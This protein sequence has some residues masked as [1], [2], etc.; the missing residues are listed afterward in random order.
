MRSHRCLPS[1]LLLL[2]A[3]LGPAPAQDQAVPDRV[4]APADFTAARAGSQVAGFQSVRTAYD[5]G[6]PG[7]FARFADDGVV[8]ALGDRTEVAFRLLGWE[9]GGVRR[10]IESRVEPPGLENGRVA[11]RRGAVRERYEPNGDGVEQTFVFDERPEGAGDLL[12][13][14]GV[15]GNVVA[16]AVPAAHQALRFVAA[17]GQQLGYGEAWAI[18]HAGRRVPMTTSYDGL[19][20]IHL[21]VPAEFVESARFPLVVDPVIGTA[22]ALAG[23]TPI[24]PDVT[25]DET[26]N[27][28]FVVWIDYHTLYGQIFDGDGVPLGSPFTLTTSR[29][30]TAIAV[31]VVDG[32]PAGDL[33]VAIYSYRW[34][35]FGETPRLGTA[36]V[37]PE[38]RAVRLLDVGFVSS[39]SFLSPTVTGS[40]DGLVGIGWL[41]RTTSATVVG[42][43]TMSLAHYPAVS[44]GAHIL[45]DSF[46]T[47]PGPALG[48]R[49]AFAERAYR[50]TV[51]GVQTS[52]ARLVWSRWFANPAPGDHDIY[53]AEI[54]LRR[55]PSVATQLVG[56]VAAVPGAAQV[57]IEELLPDVAAMAS[58]FGDPTDLRELVVWERQTGG[59]ADVIARLLAAGSASGGT[60]PVRATPA[61]E[62]APCAG[63][64]TGEF[65]VTYVD[66]T[67]PGAEQVRAACVLGSGTLAATD[68]VVTAL[69]AASLT[70]QAVSS[71]ALPLP[72]SP[73]SNRVGIVWRCT[74][75]F[76][77]AAAGFRPFEPVA[78]SSVLLGVGCV[79]PTGTVPKLVRFGSAFAGSADFGIGLRFA[80]P[81]ALAVLMLSSGPDA[82]LLPGTV[83]CMSYVA[84]PATSMFYATTSPA[85]TASVPLPLPPSIPGGTEWYCQWLVATPDWNSAGAITS[86]AERI[87]WD[88]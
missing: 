86:S 50:R 74:T 85:G 66:R 36:I 16:P 69:S 2:S 53:S 79:G 75:G 77:A 27:R 68:R 7:G 87:R 14:V 56:S 41:H 59:N 73:S 82:S 12:L 67:T 52:A 1:F 10:E 25:Y 21:S 24:G 34:G 76:V 83:D 37:E 65:T 42:A 46:S 28:F 11:Y 57:G 60:F 33:Y 71:R 35:A 70:A 80:P 39:G 63:A 38:S 54:R 15:R 22:S 6:A 62:G 48:L 31:T 19:G 64:G 47:P 58:R 23:A 84:T 30:A 17:D 29:Y 3:V 43:R 55:T 32:S 9:R 5:K 13:R 51:A 49:A 26:R 72:S 44:V 40:R 81:G 20:T 88:R 8:V 4:P 78:P 45:V 61:S 18:D